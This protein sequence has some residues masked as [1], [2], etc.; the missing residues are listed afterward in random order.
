[1]PFH[2]KQLLEVAK[3]IDESLNF[4]QRCRHNADN[5]QV[6]FSEVKV[7]VERT[8]ARTVTIELFRQILTVVPDLYKHEWER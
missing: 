7:S 3:F 8:F 5:P 1:M 6:L 2:M 4:L